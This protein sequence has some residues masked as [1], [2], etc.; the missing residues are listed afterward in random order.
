[1][2]V[3]KNAIECDSMSNHIRKITEK[4]G[5]QFG[6]TII[7]CHV[8]CYRRYLTGGHNRKIAFA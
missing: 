1:M 7:L 4:A 3:K 2:S 5:L 8:G 6:D